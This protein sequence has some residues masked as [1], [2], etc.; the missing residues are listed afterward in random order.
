[1]LADAKAPS[2]SSVMTIFVVDLLAS[3]RPVVLDDSS[4]TNIAPPG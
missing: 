2:A 4:M 1:M 3:G